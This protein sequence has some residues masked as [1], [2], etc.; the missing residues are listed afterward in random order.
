M[1]KQVEIDVTTLFTL[2]D[3]RVAVS[4]LAG[5]LLEARKLGASEIREILSPMLNCQLER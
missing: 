5:R 4:T 3:V 1:R 2:P